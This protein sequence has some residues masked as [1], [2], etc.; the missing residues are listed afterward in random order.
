MKNIFESVKQTCPSR[1]EIQANHSHFVA[2]ELSKAIILRS[3]LRNQYLKCKSEEAGTCFKIQRNLCVTLRR[4][5]KRRYHKHLELGKVND[6]F[7]ILK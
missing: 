3:K 6:S 2:K 4:K 7:G 5:A 1:N